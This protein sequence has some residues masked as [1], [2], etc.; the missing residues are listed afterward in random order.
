M[1]ASVVNRTHQTNEKKQRWYFLLHRVSVHLSGLRVARQQTIFDKA[2][3]IYTVQSRHLYVR[4]LIDC[5]A[6]AGRCRIHYCRFHVVIM[7]AVGM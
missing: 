7:V 5:R 3:V 2:Y 1:F 4:V 6:K